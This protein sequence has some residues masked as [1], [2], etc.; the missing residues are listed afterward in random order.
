MCEQVVEMGTHEELMA[1]G[2]QGAFAALVQL[3]QAH[4]EAEEDLR[5]DT[6]EV[7]EGAARNSSSFHRRSV[8]SSRKSFEESRLSAS[9]R[10]FSVNSNQ[11]KELEKKAKKVKPE[12]PSFRRLFALN[13]PEWRQ[14]LLGLTGAI[15]FGF[16]Q[17][18]Y[19]FFLG[20]M[21]A[22]F[23]N[24]NREVMKRDVRIYAGVF[25]GLAVAAFVV[26]TL[27]H[28]NFAVMGEYLTKRIRVNMLTNVLRFEVGWY[29]RDENASGAVCSRLGS[30]SNMVSLDPLWSVVM[31]LCH[32]PLLTKP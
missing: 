16:V 3:Q 29:D 4:Q 25:C 28:Y 9:K 31:K 8:S 15:A 12:V 14:A 30:D 27:Q 10:D 21:M 6:A 26:N 1:K 13:R 7:K 32:E 11:G 5:V 2:E 22:V 17:P 20:D 19:G 18:F 23:Y 24:P